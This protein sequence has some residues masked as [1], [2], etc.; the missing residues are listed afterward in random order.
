VDRQATDADGAMRAPWVVGLVASIGGL[1]AISQVLA[2]LPASYPGAIVVLQ[3]TTPTHPSQLAEILSRRT[4]LKVT[5]AQDGDRLQPGLVLVAPAGR[6]ILVCPDQTVALINSGQMPPWRPSADLL[7]TSMALSCGAHAVAV[8]L[9][10]A[11]HDGTAGAAAVKRLGGLVIAQ[12][13]ATSTEFGMPGSAIAFDKIVDHVVG[14]GG[15]GAILAAVSGRLRP[16]HSY[17]RRQSQQSRAE[18]PDAEDWNQ[19]DVSP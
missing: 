14:V 13:Q 5:L 6:H 4:A 11:G 15:I 1:D 10:G 18:Q 19:D 7:L 2:T 3:H 17:R 8:I 9:S 16:A 12:D